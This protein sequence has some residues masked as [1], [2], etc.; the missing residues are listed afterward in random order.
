[1]QKQINAAVEAQMA[2]ETVKNTIKA[3]TDAQMKTEKVQAAISQN[4]ELHP[5]TVGN[6]DF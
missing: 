3:Q 2:S 5:R 4:V 6:A 1:M